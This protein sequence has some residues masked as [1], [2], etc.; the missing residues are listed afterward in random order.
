MTKL[1]F[2]SVSGPDIP[3]GECVVPPQPLLRW[4]ISDAAL[5]GFHHPHSFH[6]AAWVLILRATIPVGSLSQY[7]IDI[8]SFY[9]VPGTRETKKDLLG[10]SF[11]IRLRGQQ[12]HL[13]HRVVGRTEGRPCT[14]KDVAQCSTN[15]TGK[16][17]FCWIHCPA[18]PAGTK[19]GARKAR[20]T[21]FS[22][23]ERRTVESPLKTNWAQ[24]EGPK[25]GWTAWEGRPRSAGVKPVRGL[26]E[27]EAGRHGAGAAPLESRLP[28]FVVTLSSHNHGATDGLPSQAFWKDPQTGCRAQRQGHHV[29]NNVLHKLNYEFM[30]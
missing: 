22:A 5:R 15:A 8:L 12:Q 18:D 7:S 16:K 4:V 14:E 25:G 3:G 13:L 30:W 2:T 24:E 29:V 28:P 17:A 11:L 9:F 23:G 6:C 26:A 27:L 21:L 1:I 19:E 20:E 10:L